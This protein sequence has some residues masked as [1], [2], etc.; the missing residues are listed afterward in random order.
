MTH[1]FWCRMYFYVEMKACETATNISDPE[2]RN[3]VLSCVSMNC[4]MQGSK[5]NLSQISLPTGI[6][7]MHSS[8]L[9]KTIALTIDIQHRVLSTLRGQLL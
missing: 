4:R 5:Y 1:T 9:Y 7:K 6:Q 3:N 2:V 8:I